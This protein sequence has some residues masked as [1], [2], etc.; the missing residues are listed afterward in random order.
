MVWWEA[1][2]GL[3][4]PLSEDYDDPDGLVTIVNKS[5]A[6]NPS[7]HAFFEAL[8]TNG[9]ACITC[10][11]PANAMSVAAR[12]VRERWQDTA[13]RDAI[14]AAIDGSNCPSLPQTERAS[15]RC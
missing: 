8:G 12:T 5:G 15:T 4:F 2:C 14:F 11:Q 13:G 1:G 6:I 3:V 9:R 7:G 10:H